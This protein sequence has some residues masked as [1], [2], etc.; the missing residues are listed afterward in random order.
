MFASEIVNDCYL[1]THR[2]S[3][4]SNFLRTDSFLSAQSTQPLNYN[5]MR[6]FYIYLQ[7]AYSSISNAINVHF[8]P[9]HQP[10]KLE[11]AYAYNRNFKDLL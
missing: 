6:K 10:E 2:F 11:K 4:L 5:E 9:A 3:Y 7:T 1:G 8:F